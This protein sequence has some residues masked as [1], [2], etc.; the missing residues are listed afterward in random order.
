MGLDFN[1]FL[2]SLY[3]QKK[4][5]NEDL[6]RYLDTG[7]ELPA[8]PE[9]SMPREARGP[10]PAAVQEASPEINTPPPVRQN[11]YKSKIEE[12]LNNQPKHPKPSLLN[13][14]IGGIAGGAQGYL[15]SSPAREVHQD[16][17]RLE[18]MF[19]T[20]RNGGHTEQLDLWNSKM[21]GLHELAGI[22]R[23]DF[24]GGLK[25]KEDISQGKLREAQGS[26]YKQRPELEREKQAGNKEI[27]QAQIES[28][29]VP[30]SMIPDPAERQKLI[31][32]GVESVSQKAFDT[33]YRH[34]D[35][36]T[37]TGSQEKIAEGN[38]ETKVTTTGMTVEG[39]HE[40]AQT[41]AKSY[42][43]RTQSTAGTA[44]ARIAAGVG[45][46][47]TGKPETPGKSE[48]KLA[49][50]IRKINEEAVKLEQALNKRFGIGGTGFRMPGSPQQLKGDPKDEKGNVIPGQKTQYDTEL[51]RIRDERQAA[52]DAAQRV[53]K[54]KK[55]SASPG[56]QPGKQET[57]QEILERLRKKLR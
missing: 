31:D 43:A 47:G 19:S 12:L 16:P 42:D 44:A 39:K 25:E 26:Y 13:A 11:P 34:K 5:G 30:V 53:Y 6:L 24:E 50:D 4:Q 54:A 55:P 10:V 41:R 56:T 38:N 7:S 36:L 46:K 2:S 40:D 3:S 29:M 9:V 23:Q 51:K 52:L 57:Q 20:L 27:K 21:K 15:N 33:Y 18:N 32:I 8:A 45:T 17:Q 22:D 28:R 14:L 37:K 1:T 48:D 49:T 35:V